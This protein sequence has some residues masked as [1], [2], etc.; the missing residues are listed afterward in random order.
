MPLQSIF[1]HHFPG[2]DNRAVPQ[3]GKFNLSL[4]N[5]I[6]SIALDSGSLSVLGTP[7]CRGN[8]HEFLV[9]CFFL[10]PANL[11]RTEVVPALLSLENQLEDREITF[12][13]IFL[14]VNEQIKIPRS[15]NDSHHTG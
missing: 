8:C 3:V 5:A 14:N 6:L 13:L 15:L 7:L 12:N 11:K 2:N 1:S 9:G 10:Q 4:M